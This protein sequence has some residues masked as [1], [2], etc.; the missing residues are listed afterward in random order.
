MYKDSKY[1]NVSLRNLFC[2]E[3][4]G[5]FINDNIK[6]HTIKK[7]KQSDCYQIVYSV[8]TNK[9]EKRRKTMSSSEINSTILQYIR[10]KKIE[11]IWT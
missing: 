8:L 9:W 3:E 11:M 6:I 10:N 1:L 4:F 5:E 7:I 2:E